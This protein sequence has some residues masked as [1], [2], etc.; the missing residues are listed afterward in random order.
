MSGTFSFGKVSGTF[1]GVIFEV[2]FP[3]TTLDE[4]IKRATE[5]FLPYARKG[6]AGIS[7]RSILY[8]LVEFEFFLQRPPDTP[9]GCFDDICLPRVDFPAA[10]A[11][12]DKRVG[13]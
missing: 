4:T 5:I 3:T 10:V 8:G 7:A 13:E 6:E 11:C 2:R 9:P 12:F 1:I